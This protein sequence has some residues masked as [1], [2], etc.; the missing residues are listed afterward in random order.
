MT[1]SEPPARDGRL[2]RTLT[3]PK[4]V[5]IIIAAAAP[6]AAMVFTV[7][8]AFSIGTGPSVPALFVFAGLTLL[9]FT[10]G[11][12]A[13]SRR[14]SHAGGFYTYIAAGLGRPVAVAGGLIAVIAYNTVTI[15]LLGAFA[16]FAHSVT[17]SYGLDVP[18]EAWAGAGLLSI[19]VLGYRHVE[20]SARVLSVLM[21]CEMAVLL[22]LDVAVLAH[23][24][25]AALPAQSFSPGLIAAPGLGVSVMFAFA[26]FIGFESA[27]LYGEEARDPGRSV[28]RATVIAVLLV[29][30]FYALTSWVAVGAVGPA[31]VRATA[32]GHL[33]DLF[34]DLGD[35]YLGG[36]TST[37]MQVL[38][39][40]SLFAG[41]LAL[42]NAANRYMFVLG[43]DRVLP[44][45]LDAVHPRHGALH[46]ACVAQSVTSAVVAAFFAA[47]GI[48]PYLG[49]STSMLGLGTLGVIALQALASLS[50][51]GYY[52]G[53]RRGHWWRTRMAP[54][55]GAVGLVAA[56]VL[57]VRNFPVLTGT[58][59]PVVTALPWL[60]PLAG[61]IGVGHAHRMR[62][63]HGERYAALAGVEHAGRGGAARPDGRD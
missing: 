50:V 41:W 1:A 51:L 22:A 55:L 25:L 30:G 44:R 34:F 13:I 38:L 7:P 36:V 47:A 37:V 24:G 19:G 2:V 46:H 48:D 20:F 28:P 11:Y 5:F 26:S 35:S 14:I 39:C 43:R 56:A 53:R 8:L 6:L 32:S 54:A 23:R 31:N 59:N 42:H 61:A 27:S 45:W 58:T 57:V 63:R 49:M 12:A 10:S 62:A 15:G 4:I 9:C 18:W 60:L 29:A 17:A 33:D 21:V 40:T 3:T 16:Y 52:R